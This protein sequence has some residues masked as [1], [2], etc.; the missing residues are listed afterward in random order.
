[1]TDFPPG[2]WSIIL[3]GDQWPDDQALMALERG[4]TN[5]GNI[6]AGFTH[7]ADMLRNA[8]TGP[9]TGQQGYTATDLRNAYHE[10]ENHA[11]RMAEKNRVK[12][13]SY[14]A[15]YDSMLSLQHDLTT[16]AEEGNKQIKAIQ[17]SKSSVEA[18]ITQITV[19]INQYRALA[20]LA[21][22]KYGGNV[23]EAI[24]RI[25]DEEGITQSARQFAQ[26]HSVNVGEMFR[27]PHD[28]ED[29]E[30]QVGASSPSPTLPQV[31]P[32]MPPN[33]QRITCRP[34]RRPRRR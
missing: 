3:V 10:G 23:L 4:K 20:N 25:L 28:Q 18:K 16:L 11:R 7:F 5:R 1:M 29:L 19:V 12:E 33:S 14:Q 8:Q 32:A 9:L 27:H 6:K 21:A 17:D 15:S 30:N 13:N 22:A 24:Q 34:K 26:S 2:E 31:S